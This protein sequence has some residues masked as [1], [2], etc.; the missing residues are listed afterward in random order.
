MFERPFPVNNVLLWNI[1][2]PVRKGESLINARL[3]LT[4]ENGS[5]Q[6]TRMRLSKQNDKSKV[7]R[8]I[9]EDEF[10]DGLVL[11]VSRTQQVVPKN[12][13]STLCFTVVLLVLLCYW[14]G[15]GALDILLLKY[16]TIINRTKWP[17]YLKRPINT[18]CCRKQIKRCIGNMKYFW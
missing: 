17:T 4:T 18:E 13:L 10:N 15:S 16:S 9:R 2:L 14:T 6:N 5:S 12:V 11:D 7:Y 1:R 8:L 3:Q